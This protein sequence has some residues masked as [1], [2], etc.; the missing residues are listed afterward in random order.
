MKGKD[1]ELSNFVT[2]IIDNLADG[3]LFSLFTTYCEANNYTD[4]MIFDMYMFNELNEGKSPLGI[5]ELVCGE[6]FNPND[7]YFKFTFYGGVQS[8]DDVMTLI[9]DY[10]DFVSWVEFNIDEIRE[11]LEDEEE[12]ELDV[13]LGLKEEEED[14]E[15]EDYD[16]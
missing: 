8:S 16:E 5:A 4:S 9:D 14:D 1:T 13:L 15:D 11:Y 12:D 7:E 10:D 3:R 2:N 6:N